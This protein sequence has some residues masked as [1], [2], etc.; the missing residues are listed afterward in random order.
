M[1]SCYFGIPK[2]NDNWRNKRPIYRVNVSLN[3]NQALIKKMGLLNMYDKV[4]T[5]VLI[6]HVLFY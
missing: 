2:L 6:V 1:I 4:M 3:F 5:M